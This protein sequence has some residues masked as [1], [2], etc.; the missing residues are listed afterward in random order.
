MVTSGSLAARYTN[1]PF[2]I[3]K[4][5]PKMCVYINRIYH[6]VLFHKTATSSAQHV[7]SSTL[8]HGLGRKTIFKT[9]EPAIVGPWMNSHFLPLG[10]RLG[11][12]LSSSGSLTSRSPE[13]LHVKKNKNKQ[14]TWLSNIGVKIKKKEKK[15]PLC[16]VM[17]PAHCRPGATSQQ[18]R[19]WWRHG[20]W[21][22]AAVFF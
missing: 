12:S 20:A 18:R 11:F 1:M 9:L 5:P 22:N 7:H 6:V 10:P 15:K 8:A 3:L 13:R 17:S 2:Y 14:K 16:P 19:D 21:L 4:L